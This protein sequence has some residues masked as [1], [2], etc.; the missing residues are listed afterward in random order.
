[1]KSHR[2]CFSV[3]R[4][5]PPMGVPR[6]SVE[7][8]SISCCAELPAT[9]GR[10]ARVVASNVMKNRPLVSVT[11][12]P[13]FHFSSSVHACALAQNNRQLRR[14]IPAAASRPCSPGGQLFVMV[15]AV[16]LVS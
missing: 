7:P 9:A 8:C 16:L 5:L 11:A 4:D 2:P 12:Y 3:L 13:I 10:S 15:A 14:V 1:M 6:H